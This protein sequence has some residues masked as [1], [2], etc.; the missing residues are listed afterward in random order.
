M[1][2]SE[3]GATQYPGFLEVPKGRP[4]SYYITDCRSLPTPSEAA[5]LRVVRRVL[6]RGVN[7]IQVREKDLFDRK[8]F[9]L[10]RRIVELAREP[11]RDTYCKVLVNGRADIALAAGADGVHLPSSGL[12]VADIRAWTPKDFIVGVSVHS[13]REIRIACEGS[14]DYILV[15]HVFPTASKE[16]M[17]PA[18]GIG[19]L[20]R[21]V[22]RSSVPI[23]ALGGVTAERIPSVLEAGAAGVAG[24]SL[25]QKR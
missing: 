3:Q 8:L 1:S 7:F 23:L 19:F 15:G 10:T 4:L 17:G 12:A 22:A 24:I 6:A 5:L 9:D 14:V 25:F 21:A 16:G 2:I 18:L 11:A 13:L 20:R